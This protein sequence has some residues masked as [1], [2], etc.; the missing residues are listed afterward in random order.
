MLLIVPPGT[1]DS[2]QSVS[3]NVPPLPFHIPGMIP[4]GLV[5]D[6]YVDDLKQQHPGLHVEERGRQTV[7]GTEARG[8]RT[9][10]QEGG[11]SYAEAALLLVHGDR[12]YILRADAPA[13]AFGRVR[14]VFD[15]VAGSIRWLK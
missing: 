3:L 10:W 15:A 6:G 9:T 8:V 13:D 12:V 2:R 4:M 5:E 1:T 14:E 11:R 7:A